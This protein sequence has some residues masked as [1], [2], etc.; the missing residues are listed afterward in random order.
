[1]TVQNFRGKSAEISIEKR[2]A[3]NLRLL[4]ICQRL[5]QEQVANAANMSRSS[6]AAIENGSRQADVNTVTLLSDYYGIS[7]DR[8]LKEDL[9]LLYLKMLKETSNRYTR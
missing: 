9:S 5:S 3:K 7:L 6:Y 4:R 8:L 1:M 2:I